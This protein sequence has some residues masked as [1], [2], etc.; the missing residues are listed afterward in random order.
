MGIFI[1]RHSS[2]GFFQLV[3]L[4]PSK[5][6]LHFRAYHC[7]QCFQPHLTTLLYHYCYQHGQTS[8]LSSC[9]RSS[10]WFCTGFL[11][12][13]S[14][15]KVSSV[16]QLYCRSLTFGTK[17]ANSITKFNHLDR[18]LIIAL[19]LLVGSETSLTKT[20]LMISKHESLVCQCPVYLGQYSIY[21]YNKCPL[22]AYHMSCHIAEWHLKW[23]RWRLNL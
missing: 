20:L 10:Y 12:Q 14:K 17:G 23:Q 18:I 5:P 21:I 22:N 7:W 9:N 11:K 2:V 19:Q 3:S 15:V 16:L 8:R 4:F 1:G 13:V 6:F